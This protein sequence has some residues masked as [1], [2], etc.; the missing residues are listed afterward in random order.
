MIK[1]EIPTFPIPWAAPRMSKTG[2]IYDIRSK[3]KNWLKWHVKQ[4]YKKEPVQGYVV[5]DFTFYFPVPASATL[6]KKALMLAGEIIPTA[7]D[8]TNCQKLTEDCLKNIIISDDRNVAKISSQKL[9]GEKEN[10]IIKIWT[11]REFR[12]ET[13]CR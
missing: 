3:E 8:C 7:C 9:Y 11:L 12:N 6:K 5:L 4:L 10:I 1:I 2:G 13:G